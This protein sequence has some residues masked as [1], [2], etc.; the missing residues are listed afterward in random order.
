M[1]KILIV[2]DYQ[3][4]FISGALGFDKALEIKGNI[5]KKLNLYSQNNYQIAFTMDTHDDFYLDTLEGKFL[6]IKHCIKGSNGHKLHPDLEDYT[7]NALIFEKNT[8]GSKE[9]GKYL[10]ENFFDEIEFCGLISNICV[11]S[12]AII[13]QTFSPNS[14]IIIDRSATISHIDEINETFDIYLSSLGIKNN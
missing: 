12:N 14:K 13:A 9:L 2:V 1:K 7:K 10:E 8:F 5:I 6:P 3:Q 4:D 11:L